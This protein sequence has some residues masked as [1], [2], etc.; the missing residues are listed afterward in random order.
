METKHTKEYAEEKA[1][2]LY[3]LSKIENYEVNAYIKGYMKAIEETA[4]PEMLDVLIRL[5]SLFDGRKNEME[6]LINKVISKATK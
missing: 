3:Y 4:A 1:M 6:R 5:K 2:N